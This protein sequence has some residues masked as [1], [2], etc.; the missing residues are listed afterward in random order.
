MSLTLEP[1]LRSPQ[2]LHFED[3]MNIVDRIQPADTPVYSMM[4]RE[5]ELG[6]TTFDW[7]VDSWPAPK[8][9][10]GPGDGYDVQ[11]A[12][13]RDV[14]ANRRKMGNNGQAFRRA[15]GA[16]WIANAVPKMVGSGKGNLLAAGAADATTLLKQ[17]IE[18]AFCSFDQTAVQDVGG[19]SG[20]TMAGIP[21]LIDPANKYA[22]ASAYAIG[23]PTDLHYAPTAACVTGA[24]TAVASLFSLASLRTVMR[25]LRGAT[26]RNKDYQFLVGLDL[27]AQV[28]SLVDPASSSVTAGG[29]GYSQTRTF[30]QP[31]SDSEL[32]ISIDVIRTDYGRLLVIPTDYLGN[33][34]TN[35][36]GTAQGDGARASREFV[37]K[38]YSGLIL[39]REK[40]FKR[41]GVPFETEEL[42]K[43]GGGTKKHMRCY[44]TC[45]VYNPTGFGFYKLT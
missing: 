29:L 42:A 38:P 33:T 34:T 1:G 20:G 37:A 25:A 23:K 40:M 26:Q 13:I 8:G 35:A 22:A 15:F 5:Y 45:G 44:V 39:S 16:G 24:A 30:T 43:N 12:E 6:A 17:D 11:D 18:C 27:R 9:A 4:G 28:T 21:K 32:G 36:A 41:W 31:I 3:L 10:E 19:A 2:R 7:F 14:T